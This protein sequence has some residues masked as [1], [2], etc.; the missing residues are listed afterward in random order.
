MDANGPTEH[1]VEIVLCN[2][3]DNLV[4]QDGLQ[5]RELCQSPIVLK[6][7]FEYISRSDFSK[8]TFNQETEF[9]AFSPFDSAQ[10]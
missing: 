8:S 6:Q 10:A 9:Y 2:K 3:D 7:L 5:T 1:N 4:C